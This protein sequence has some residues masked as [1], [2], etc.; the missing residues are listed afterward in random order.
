M[1]PELL[2][3]SAASGGLAVSFDS[4]H[5]HVTRSYVR[6]AEMLGGKVE[7]GQRPHMLVT[8]WADGRRPGVWT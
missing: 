4:V 3:P 2:P 1:L 6:A 5:Q 8:S 7:N